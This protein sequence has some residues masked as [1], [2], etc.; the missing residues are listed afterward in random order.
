M[1]PCCTEKACWFLAALVG[2]LCGGGTAAYCK[3]TQAREM[4]LEE[5]LDR[6]GKTFEPREVELLNAAV[7]W[8]AG[9]AVDS[10][11]RHAATSAEAASQL[12][13]LRAKLCPK[14]SQPVPT[15]S[16]PEKK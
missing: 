3:L 15:P 6:L 9:V 1:N 13:R 8:R 16:S 5:A 14:S 4:A 12:E 10:L 7:G 2:I 11:L